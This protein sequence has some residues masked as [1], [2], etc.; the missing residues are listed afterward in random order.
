[1]APGGL[2]A[3]SGLPAPGPGPRSPWG[4]RV[5]G[6]TPDELR[7]EGS[8]FDGGV[9][10]RGRRPRS[11]GGVERP[12]GK[13]DR[14]GPR[15][16]PGVGSGADAHRGGRP[17]PADPALLR[18]GHEAS[19]ARRAAGGVQGRRALHHA[20]TPR[21]VQP[22]GGRVRPRGAWGTGARGTVSSGRC[23]TQASPGG[24]VITR[25]AGI[26]GG[27]WTDPVG[28][29]GCTVVLCPSG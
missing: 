12:P 8:P 17:G 15:R 18:P 11:G 6:R 13:P 26:R 20:R 3:R 14:D 4:P 9:R 23:Q 27:H 5:P 16:R 7:T 28:L 10:G 25:V 29:T 22:H 19:A 1:G 2:E 24:R 21:P